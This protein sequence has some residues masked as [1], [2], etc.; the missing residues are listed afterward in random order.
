MTTN[1]RD[2][3]TI[4]TPDAFSV[5]EALLGMPLAKPSSR[6]WAIIIDLI[7][8]SLLTVATD[9][10]SLI[11][12]GIVGAFFLQ[13]AFRKP[14]RKMGQ[15][16]SVLFRGA[17]G[18]LG[19]L[20]L[21]GV[22]I[23]Y[24]VVRLGDDEVR[25]APVSAQA[26]ANAVDVG[27]VGGTSLSSVLGAVASGVA[28][29]D[30]AEE[31]DPDVAE[32]MLLDM[33]TLAR[34]MGGEN[35]DIRELLGS[36]VDEDSEF[37]DDPDAFVERVARRWEAENGVSGEPVEETD[38]LLAARADVADLSSA[39][40]LAQFAALGDPDDFDSSDARSV[41]LRER[42]IQIVAADSLA[43]LGRVTGDLR[44]DLA[45]SR[46][47][48][49]VARTT[50][51]EGNAGFTG[52]MRDIWQQLGSAFGLWSIYFT[53][54]L[55]LFK[56]QTVGKKVM[57]I[58]VLRLDG[59]PINWWAA[60]ERGGG[61]FAG[62]ATGLLGFVQVYWDANRQCVHDKIGGTVVVIDGSAPS[63]AWREAAGQPDPFSAPRK[64]V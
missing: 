44:D 62:I 27:T 5:S 39:E 29:L 58:R 53:V 12:W 57:G 7:V 8:I 20:I 19:M 22:A 2:P 56:G 47:E 36:M 1:I 52:L 14:S 37:T 49:S 17:T 34:E 23:G 48:L 60:F 16:T 55:T 28:A 3:R 59:E 33:V 21:S 61:Y 45:A 24:L 13:M 64:P 41:A 35:V 30:L 38:E 18:C 50:I 32:G 40:V 11:I 43:T 25:N 4:I 26:A 15:V 46:S 9:S 51:E 54:M 6:L 63:D 10:I 42:A 31:D